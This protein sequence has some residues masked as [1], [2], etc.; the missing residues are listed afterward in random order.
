MCRSAI[1]KKNHRFFYRSKFD[2][3]K[4]CYIGIIVST[5]MKTIVSWFLFM[6]RFVNNGSFS[7]MRRGLLLDMLITM[8]TMSRFK[9]LNKV[10]VGYK[11][12]IWNTNYITTGELL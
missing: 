10:T 1:K 4:A 9:A 3:V 8:A 12:S 7:R 6:F 2:W 11:K 5:K